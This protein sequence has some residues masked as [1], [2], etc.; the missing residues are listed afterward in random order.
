MV[1]FVRGTLTTPVAVYT[2]PE[3]A[4]CGSL[5]MHAKYM[6]SIG[7]SLAGNGRY[8][9]KTKLKVLLK[10]QAADA[11]YHE[12]LGVHIIDRLQLN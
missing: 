6:M 5:K 10:S 3:V 8:C 12:I 11:K 4:M 7:K 1:T 2:H 9:F